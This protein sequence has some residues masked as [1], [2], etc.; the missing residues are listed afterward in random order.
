MIYI[1]YFLAAF[2]VLWEAKCLL[3]T[4]KVYKWVL[5]FKSLDKSDISKWTKSQRSFVLYMYGYYIWIFI[6]LFTFQWPLFLFILLMSLI[7]K[8]DYIWI[9]RLDA[10]ITILI[11]IFIV[12]NAYHFKIDVFK[13]IIELI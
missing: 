9:R 1:F 12:L 7:P 10:L 3:E 6:G 13:L 11:L 2:P 8:G 4:E 5:N